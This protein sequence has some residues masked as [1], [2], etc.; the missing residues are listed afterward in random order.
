MSKGTFSCP[1]CGE[2]VPVRAKACPHCGACEKS[3]WKEGAGDIDG[4]DLPGGD[5][6]Y[7]KF[8]ADEFGTKPKFE[9]KQLLWKVTALILIILFIAAFI[10]ELSPK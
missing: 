9:G 6:D 3:G 1:A 8:V 5:F 10:F 7:D 2:N 4:L